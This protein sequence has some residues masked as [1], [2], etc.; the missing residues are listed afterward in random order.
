MNNRQEFL[1]E[2]LDAMKKVAEEG[3]EY[4]GRGVAPEQV[5]FK[6]FKPTLAD[7]LLFKRIIE[8]N[9]E[10]LLKEILAFPKSPT[11]NELRALNILNILYAP[12]YLS[13]EERVL[14]IG[15]ARERMDRLV[16]YV[17]EQKQLRASQQ[18]SEESGR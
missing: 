9:Y 8:E 17:I 18:A 12:F 1:K 5:E 16:D 2:M 11:I 3:D 15:E 10:C 4:R 13:R 14:N 6:S 7:R